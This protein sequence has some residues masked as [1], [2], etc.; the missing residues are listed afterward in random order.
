MIQCC[1]R[2]VLTALLLVLLYT[3]STVKS[4]MMVAQTC[5]AGF[6][7]SRC[8]MLRTLKSGDVAQQLVPSVLKMAALSTWPDPRRLD[9]FV[10]SSL[11]VDCLLQ[12]VD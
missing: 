9:G 3:M 10:V 11:E 4:K 2:V 7:A 8:D 5:T 12:S 1:L 6:S